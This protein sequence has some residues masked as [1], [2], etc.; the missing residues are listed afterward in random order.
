MYNK[1]ELFLSNLLNSTSVS[2]DGTFR[3]APY[4]FHQLYTFNFFI[5]RLQ[6]RKMF[7]GIYILMTHKS[8]FLYTLVIEWMIHY[9]LQNNIRIAWEHMMADYEIA[10]KYALQEI[11]HDRIDWNGCYF[12]FSQ[13][14][15]RK[16]ADVG[17]STEYRDKNTLFSILVRKLR[18][19][20]F[21]Y[22]RRIGD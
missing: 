8:I 12:H 18:S 19:L 1:T 9:A 17:L 4:P 20:A 13:A 6:T 3:I 7:C 14:I 22:L 10:V 15:Q 21:M 16:I 2:G 5:T 11:L